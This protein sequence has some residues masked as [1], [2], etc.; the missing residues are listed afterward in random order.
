M[1]ACKHFKAEVYIVE[2]EICQN[3]MNKSE[4]VQLGYA[5][6]VSEK[7]CVLP[8]LRRSTKMAII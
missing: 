6:F 3:Q 2:T 4:V 1:Y 5:Q 7:G 8:T